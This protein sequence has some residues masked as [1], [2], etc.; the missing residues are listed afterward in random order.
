MIASVAVCRPLLWTEECKT[1]Y[2]ENRMITDADI[3]EYLLG[4]LDSDLELVESIDEKI[5]TDPEFSVSVDVIEDE[6]IE[7]YLEDSLKSED[8]RAVERHFL[9]PP[10]R[11]H[12]LRTARLVSRYLEGESRNV[13][14][15]NPA[16]ARRQFN[17]LRVGWA[18]PSFRTCAEIAASTVLVISI[19][20]LLNQ[21]RE[22]D[23]AIKQ[24]GEKL[25]QE[26]QRS[27]ASNQQLQNA[28]QS[29]QPAVAMLNLVR[30]GLQRGEAQ[31][32]EVKLNSGTRL[33]Y[34]EVALPSGA[35]GSSRVELRHSGK[36][37]WSRNGVDAVAVP[38]GAILRLDIPADLLAQGACE[39]LVKPAGDGAISYWFSVSKLL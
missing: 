38:G 25:S 4:R 24:A 9:R 5:L 20:T 8:R 21:R 11:Q 19:L 3:R 18:L 15:E 14:T 1:E 22:L 28:F 37:I 17:V 36:M 29:L 34:V 33:L 30:P 26:R 31:L 27:A 2:M 23:I 6:I 35:P 39:L 16:P 13:T 7:Q 10:E 12:K 32:P